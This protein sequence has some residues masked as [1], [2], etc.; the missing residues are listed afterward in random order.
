MNANYHQ[1]T[2]VCSKHCSLRGAVRLGLA[3]SVA[4]SA[5]PWL[6]AH[7][8]ELPCPVTAA[9]NVND[10]ETVASGSIC[11]INGPSGAVTISSPNGLLTNAGTLSNGVGATLK[12]YAGS[13]DAGSDG[14]PHIGLF[15]NSYLSSAGY[16]SNAG[17]F[18]NWGTVTNTGAFSNSAYIFQ[19]GAILRNQSGGTLLNTGSITNLEAG[20]YNSGI[21]LNDGAIGGVGSGVDNEGRWVNSGYV[22]DDGPD[23]YVGNGG[24]FV[25]T[26][27]VS[28]YAFANWSGDFI[29]GGNLEANAYFQNFATLINNP[30]GT[31][32]N[33][34]GCC[35]SGNEPPIGYSYNGGT[36]INGG[37]ITNNG[38]L[39]SGGSVINRSGG[40]MVN[41]LDGLA[42]Y[43]FAFGFY[44]GGVFNNEAG[45]GISNS[46]A[47]GNGGSL[48]NNG[49]ITNSDVFKIGSTGIVIGTGTFVQTAG[50]TTVDGSLSQATV[51]IE[52]G[53]LNG[54]GSVTSPNAVEISADAVLSPGSYAGDT[55]VFTINAPLDLD[56][57]L[58]VDVASLLSY[59]FIGVGGGVTFGP[60][61]LISLVLNQDANQRA[62]DTFNFLDALALLDVTNL[63]FQC[64]GLRAGLGCNLNTITD[65]DNGLY[66]QLELTQVPEPGSFGIMALGLGL[67]GGGLR[68]RSRRTRRG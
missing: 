4:G 6:P 13:Y 11:N 56:G 12:N 14:L 41:T 3:I 48:V 25:N 59:D 33:H 51:D 60:D 67:V 29:N 38:S 32:V 44:N 31:L 17:F 37:T 61:S 42:Y 27:T 15:N 64:N 66:L 46:G 2:E 45:A 68:F 58:D 40:T 34:A 35:F 1:K 28:T 18:R 62:G 8:G 20:I 16:L 54:T 57:T 53:T 47:F 10:S 43:G 22:S 30:G 5:L 49:I 65:G 21:F 19:E 52:G 7:A 50:T 23:G 39:F 63:D 9:V 55:A 24:A 36:I 26:G